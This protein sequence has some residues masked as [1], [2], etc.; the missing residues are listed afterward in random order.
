MEFETT[1][2]RTEEM[3]TTTEKMEEALTTTE[4]TEVENTT[5][6][7]DEEDTSPEKIEAEIC[8]TVQET[9]S[10]NELQMIADKIKNRTNWKITNMIDASGAIFALTDKQPLEISINYEVLPR[11][12]LTI[13]K[14]HEVMDR[15][16]EETYVRLYYWDSFYFLGKYGG[17]ADRER[18]S[19]CIN[20]QK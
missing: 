19:D 17:V 10:D 15:L 16:Q 1:T 14:L 5:E 3:A 2:M 12:D 11:S 20:H 9:I 4:R 6:E 13:A 18:L 8:L 7:I